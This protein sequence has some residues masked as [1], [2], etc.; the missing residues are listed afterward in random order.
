MKYIDVRQGYSPRIDS[1]SGRIYA[2]VEGDEQHETLV[3]SSKNHRYCADVNGMQVHVIFDD[4]DIA[5]AIDRAA[6]IRRHF[7]KKRDPRCFRIWNAMAMRGDVYTYHDATEKRVAERVA[8]ESGYHCTGASIDD[9]GNECLTF[10]R[11]GDV[12]RLEWARLGS[13]GGAAY[14]IK[15]R[16]AA[17][18]NRIAFI[19]AAK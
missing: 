3:Y 14:Q 8:T 2:R 13:I 6:R 7:A 18:S 1:R 5:M 16:A 17:R 9:C 11:G 19:G 10:E 4:A 15:T 12:F